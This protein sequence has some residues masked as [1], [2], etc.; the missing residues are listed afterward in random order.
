MSQ[1]RNIRRQKLEFI[2]H[3]MFLD[4]AMVV[5]ECKQLIKEYETARPARREEL[6]GLPA[7]TCLEK[8]MDKYEEWFRCDGI[9]IESGEK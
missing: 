5:S 3:D 6:M 1:T 4:A 2:A 9:D 7:I 8:S